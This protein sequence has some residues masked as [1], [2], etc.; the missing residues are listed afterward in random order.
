MRVGSVRVAVTSGLVR[1]GAPCVNKAFSGEEGLNLPDNSG[2]KINT[3]QS[4][5]LLLTEK[6]SEAMKCTRLTRP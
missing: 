4:H 2:V 3:K 1:L 6:M 5:V